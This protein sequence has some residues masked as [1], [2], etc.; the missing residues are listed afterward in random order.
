[1]SVVLLIATGGWQYLKGLLAAETPVYMGTVYRIHY[2]AASLLIF[3]SAAFISDWWR[4]GEQA[5]T[6]GKGQSIPG[7]DHFHCADV[8]I[9][10]DHPLLGNTP[11][12]KGLL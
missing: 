12:G 10:G 3:A 8:P 4:R 7:K 11:P 1:M 5:L 2:F 6:P 9:G